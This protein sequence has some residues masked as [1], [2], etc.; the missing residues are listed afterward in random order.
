[1]FTQMSLRHSLVVLCFTLVSALYLVSSDDKTLSKQLQSSNLSNISDCCPFLKIH[2]TEKLCPLCYTEYPEAQFRALLNY[3]RRFIEG[4]Q[5]ELREF[6]NDMDRLGQIIIDMVDL[7]KALSKTNE[8]LSYQTNFF[9]SE[10][11]F[12][13]TYGVFALFD[14]YGVINKLASG[15]ESIVVERWRTMTQLVKEF[16]DLVDVS[17]PAREMFEG[18]RIRAELKLEELWRQVPADAY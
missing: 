14:S 9:Y 16:E 17:D 5:F 7:N 1:M 6:E 3:L 12:T 10:S 13:T 8:Q 4:D 18:Y 15:Y 11:L 2:P